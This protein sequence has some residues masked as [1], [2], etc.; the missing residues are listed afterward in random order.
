MYIA[1]P[2]GDTTVRGRSNTETL[3]PTIS[4]T[5]DRRG[6][7]SHAHTM[8]LPPIDT[9]A[10]SFTIDISKSPVE[11]LAS[12][13]VGE[14]SEQSIRQSFTAEVTRDETDPVGEYSS[15]TEP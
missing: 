2:F 15:L 8:L 12:A 13:S 5:T 10:G 14:S 4:G 6:R 11:P 3:P 7:P 1:A 9:G